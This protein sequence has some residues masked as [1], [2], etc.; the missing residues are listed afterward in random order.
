M[1]NNP[2]RENGS[3]EEDDDDD[4]EE[5]EGDS[6][7][8][9]LGETLT[10]LNSLTNMSSNSVNDESSEMQDSLKHRQKTHRG[11]RTTP[12]LLSTS[13]GVSLI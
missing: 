7:N 11:A 5:E 12:N 10:G 13:L 6:A 3:D 2:D 1:S 9:R 8:M 4:F